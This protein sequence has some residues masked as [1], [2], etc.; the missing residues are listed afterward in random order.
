[1]GYC[2]REDRPLTVS[3]AK[4][5]IC[6][7]FFDKNQRQHLMDRQLLNRKGYLER[8]WIEFND[9]NII[10]MTW[11]GPRKNIYM[12]PGRMFSTSAASASSPYCLSPIESCLVSFGEGWGLHLASVQGYASSSAEICSAAKLCQWR[13]WPVN[14]VAHIGFSTSSCDVST[15]T[16]SA[17]IYF[18]K[19]FLAKLLFSC[20]QN[21]FG[22]ILQNI[23]VHLENKIQFSHSGAKR[24]V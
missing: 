2:S 8:A 19:R 17:F 23:F 20:L 24:N 22:K 18:V 12:V 9:H 14:T 15:F 1:M 5:T 7:L 16:V 21:C 11:H 4:H 6:L 3:N 13:L 10:S